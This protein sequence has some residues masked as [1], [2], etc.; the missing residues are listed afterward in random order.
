MRLSPRQREVLGIIVEFDSE[1][2]GDVWSHCD[3]L[4]WGVRGTEMS[5]FDRT[6]KAL[7]RRGLV[8]EGEYRLEVTATGRAAIGH[9][10][11]CGCDDCTV[12]TGEAHAAADLAC[13]RKWTCQ[14]GACKRARKINIDRAF[15]KLEGTEAKLANIRA[16][17][18]L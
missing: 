7:V 8:H 10:M 6:A 3:Y 2:W 12:R 13:G 5:N 9:P 4:K 17:K 15:A 16:I 14:C 1:C 11:G 18:A